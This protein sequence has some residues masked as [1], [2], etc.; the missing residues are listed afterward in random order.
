MNAVMGRFGGTGEVYINEFS[1]AL[2]AALAPRAPAP[3]PSP[4]ARAPAPL[5]AARAPVPAAPQAVAN[6]DAIVTRLAQAIQ[7]SGQT[8]E[9]L[10][11]RLDTN[12][13]GKLSRHELE[14]A[15]R[16]L[17]P[18]LSVLDMEAIMG[19]FGG[20]GEVY[21]NEFSAALSAALAPRAPAPPPTPSAYASPQAVANADAVVTRL[22]QAI[23]RSG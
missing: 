20:T 23:Q 16:S 9:A 21:I 4:S 10:F 3:P 13:D 17:E 6:A 7:R 14:P 15:M 22:A 12:R 8:V 1:A 5:P 2:S 11:V 18:G 19:R